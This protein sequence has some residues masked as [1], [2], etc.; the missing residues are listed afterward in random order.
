[1]T[2]AWVI[3]TAMPPT[4]GHANL[5]RFAASLKVDKVQ[6]I[7]CTQPHEPWPT[8][9]YLAVSSF[10]SN[11]GNQ[12]ILSAY[13]EP[14]WLNVEVEQDPSAPGFWEF[15]DKTIS[16]YGFKPGDIWVT[17]EPYGQTLADRLGG[18]FIP[19]D[20]NRELYP[21][22]ATAVRNNVL[23]NFDKIMTEF[24]PFLRKTIT[25]FGAES[26][27]KTTLSKAMALELDGHWVYEW[28]RPY[29][30]TVGSEITRKAMEE[31]HLGQAAAQ[32]HAK[33]FTDKPY[34]IQDTDL[35]STI[36]YWEQP[37]WESVLGEVPK[38][39]ITEAEELKSDLYIITKSNIPFEADELRYGGDRRE[40]PDEFWI[41]VAEKYNL[42]YIVLEHADFVHRFSQALRATDKLFNDS[43]KLTYD[44]QGF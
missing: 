26:T 39:L 11:M 28:A 16:E 6:V 36:G 8:E 4:K 37:H 30:E 22:K 24:Q 40:S 13:T 15:W 23:G 42:N 2:T 35:Y 10:I 14:I 20:P 5:I 19:Y 18:V 17:S 21:V 32:R 27:G 1:M 34:I 31:I 29:L 41:G 44:R 25:V 43:H 33:M 38:M 3:M 12:N 9:R 7:V